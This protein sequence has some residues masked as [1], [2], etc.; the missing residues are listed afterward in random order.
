MTEQ[1]KVQKDGA[2]RVI[3]F[4]N[5]PQNYISHVMLREFYT[6]LLQFGKYFQ[7]RLTISRNGRNLYRYM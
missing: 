4:H 5:P 1:L 2:V 6:Q 3:E 7:E